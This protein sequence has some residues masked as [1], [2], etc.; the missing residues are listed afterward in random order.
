MSIRELLVDEAARL[1]LERAPV[2]PLRDVGGERVA[3]DV[4]G[5]LGHRERVFEERV[6]GAHRVARTEAATSD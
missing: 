2:D 6:V 3:Q 1:E 4:R 5:V